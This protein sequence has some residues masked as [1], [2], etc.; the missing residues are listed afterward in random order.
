[1]LDSA[2][3]CTNVAVMEKIVVASTARRREE[4]APK[5]VNP[6]DYRTLGAKPPTTA[7][8]DSLRALLENRARLA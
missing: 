2:A 6:A 8:R 1:L 5:V 4:G 3:E 7:E